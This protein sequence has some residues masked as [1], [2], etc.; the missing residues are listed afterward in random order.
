MTACYVCEA[1]ITV[2]VDAHDAGVDDRG[3]ELFACGRC[4]EECTR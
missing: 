4:C 3:I 2:G 1:Q